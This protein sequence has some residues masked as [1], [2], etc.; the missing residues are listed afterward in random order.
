MQKRN[1]T[2]FGAIN[3]VY[4]IVDD[5]IVAANYEKEHDAIMLLL[6][7]RAK[8][9]DVCFIRDKILFKVNS[10]RYVRHLRTVEGLKPDDE[11]INAIVNM[12][13]PADVSSLQ[14]LLGMTKYQMNAVYTK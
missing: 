14:R 7:N 11:K 13:P 9:K 2:V 4:V 6:L 8:E 3:G 1:K 10:V 5:V 12:A